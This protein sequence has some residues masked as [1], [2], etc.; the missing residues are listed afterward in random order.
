MRPDCNGNAYAPGGPDY[1][2]TAT[3]AF[4]VRPDVGW[5]PWTRPDGKTATTAECGREVT[6]SFW[7]CWQGDG[8][9]PRMTF[10]THQNKH[11][12]TVSHFARIGSY[13]ETYGNDPDG[14]VT[15]GEY[16][17]YINFTCDRLMFAQ[18]CCVNNEELLIPSPR[19][20]APRRANATNVSAADRARRP[21]CS[22]SAS[23][24]GAGGIW[25]S[26]EYAA[27]LIGPKRPARPVQGPD[28]EDIPKENR[29]GIVADG[30]IHDCLVDGQDTD[31]IGN[32]LGY[33]PDGWDIWDPAFLY[34][35]GGDVEH[36]FYPIYWCEGASS[37][38]NYSASRLQAGMRGQNDWGTDVPTL[39]QDSNASSDMIRAI[40]PISDDPGAASTAFDLGVLF[41]TYHYKTVRIQN[42]TVEVMAQGYF[43]THCIVR[44]RIVAPCPSA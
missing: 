39:L 33:G 37:A 26:K 9:I 24:L 1:G 27:W 6:G 44:A 3:P 19:W 36:G 5:Q 35:V 10:D 4:R 25:S 21:F 41:Q 12:N 22:P 32:A 18:N 34:T 28:W 20:F 8:A 40:D 14:K 31:E 30:V 2:F 38:E 43:N 15:R 17:H 11:G 13:T 16:H 7:L 23:V 29:T 42:G